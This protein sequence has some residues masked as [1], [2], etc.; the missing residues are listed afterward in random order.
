MVRG[1]LCDGLE[2]IGNVMGNALQRK[3]IAVEHQQLS[4]HLRMQGA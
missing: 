4:E 1:Y 2:L 3:R